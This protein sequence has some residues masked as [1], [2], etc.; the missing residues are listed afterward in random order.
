VEWVFVPAIV[1][2]F[3]LPRN[4][5][6]RPLR[7]TIELLFKPV[8]QQPQIHT[9]RCPKEVATAGIQALLLGWVLVEG[10][11]VDL[12]VKLQRHSRAAAHAAGSSTDS[13]GSCQYLGCDKPGG[14]AAAGVG[15][16]LVIA[17]I[18][19]MFTRLA[20][21]SAQ[22]SRQRAHQASEVVAWLSGVIWT[23]PRVVQQVA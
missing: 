9:L 17:T 8:K 2:V 6:S 4:F 22:P 21:L 23:P 11:A 20:A 3:L 5:R 14:D 18:G 15:R 16:A 7:R 12:Q 1:R 10:M 19:G 13:G